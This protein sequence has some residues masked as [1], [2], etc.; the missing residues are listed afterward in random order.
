MKFKQLPFW[1][2]S[3]LFLFSFILVPIGEAQA[4]TISVKLVNYLGNR[5][6]VSFDTEGTYKLANNNTRYSGRDRFEVANNIAS[7]GWGSANTV[8]VVNYLAFADAL[9]AAPLAKKLD[10][11]ILLTKPDSL[12]DVTKSKIQALHPANVLIIGGAGSVSTNVANQLKG[13]V[14]SVDRVAG[15]DRFE[16]AKNIAG[17]LGSSSSAIVTNGLIF[18]DALAIAS[19]AAQKQIPILLTYNNQIP[20]S[21]KI[22]LQGKSSTLI[23]GGTGSV[24]TV[25]EKQLAAP[26][27]IGGSDRYEVSANIVKQLNLDAQ[28]VFLSNGLTFAD[29]LTGSVL[30]AKQG[31]P[32]LLTAPT[33]IPTVVLN[34]MK[35]KQTSI[36]SVLGGTASVSN[37]VVSSLPNEYVIEPKTKYTVA[38]ENGRLGL[39]KGSQKIKDFGTDPFTLATNYSTSN[40]INIYGNGPTSYLGNMEFSIENGS[41]VRPINR[42]I[43]FEDY[44]KNV[45]PREM[46][47]SWGNFNA[48]AGRD[49]MDALRAQA[50]AA[51]TYAIDEVGKTVKDDQSFQVYGGYRYYSSAAGGWV[52]AWDPN[53]TRAVNETSGKILK[54]NGSLVDAVFSSS[55]GG[56]TVK[57]TDEWPSGSPLGYLIAQP[58]SYDNYKWTLKVPIKQID[59]DGKDLENYGYWW[60]NSS[61]AN[62]N[63]AANVKNWLRSQN[64]TTLPDNQIKIINVSDF[65][66]AP[67]RN[68]SQRSLNGSIT[69]DY[70]LYGQ[71]D[72][73]SKQIKKNTVQINNTIKNFRSWFGGMDF[74]STYLDSV[75]KDANFIYINGKGFGHGIG[76]SQQGAYHRALAG[77]S[78]TTIL[79]FYY[80]GAAIVNQ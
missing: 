18:S 40:M 70:M 43:S 71:V 67:E 21:T 11:P 74:K 45:V 10:A 50:I 22:A 12:P 42:N 46:P 49:G 78:Y 48:S 51:R 58:D 35:D 34:T 69:V 9:A 55:N 80:H 30:A 15:N 62:A 16:V 54:Y 65:N 13:L 20:T 38:V 75:A 25:V 56:Y 36:V 6:S 61:E 2:I 59:L 39:Y 44:L 53:S 66:F 79:S 33:E 52:N 7:G 3:C 76:L 63:L 28:T 72:P 60:W 37:Q 26:K 31:A 29:A 19:Y 23:I 73:T 32:L 8:I 5:P 27:R 68:S 1:I 64:I 77:Q 4:S 14:Q 57:N 24:G 41:Y 17:K 47:A